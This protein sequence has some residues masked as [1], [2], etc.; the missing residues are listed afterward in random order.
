MKELLAEAGVPTARFGV[1]TEVG[2][3][4]GVP[5]A[6]CPAPGWS[7]PTAWPPARGCW[8]PTRWPRPR[9]TWP[10][11]CPGDAFGDAG[12]RVVIEEGL[13]GPECSLLVLCDGRAAGRR[14]PRPRTSSGVTTATRGPNT[15]GMGAYSPVPV[16]RR[17]RWST[18]WWTRRWP[19]WSAAL[20]ARGIDYRGVLYAGLMLTPDGPEGARVQRPVRRPRDPGGPA[21][22]R[23]R[24]RPACWPRRPPARWSTTPRFAADAAVCVVL[25]SE[26]YP[27]SPRTGDADRRPRRRPAAGRRGDRLPRRHRRR[28]GDRRRA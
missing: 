19:R 5:R 8:S 14:W 17:R 28:P 10:P 18:S 1:F 6:P 23:G 11:S 2:P 20:R 3:A 12:R 25:A 22:L 27:E 21:P 4:V 24:P 13:T 15:G 26:G 16:G 9:P 7:R